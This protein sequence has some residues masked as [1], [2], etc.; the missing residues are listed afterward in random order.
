MR[1]DG[2]SSSVVEV[3]LEGL[4]LDKEEQAAARVL[5][6][7]GDGQM[8]PGD[9]KAAAGIW[10]RVLMV[11]AVGV[12]LVLGVIHGRELL[13]GLYLMGNGFVLN[14]T[15]EFLEQFRPAPIPGLSEREQ[16]L[17]SDWQNWNA[18]DLRRLTVLE[19]DDP[20]VFCAYSSTFL[21]QHDKLPEGY[22][23]TAQR[24]APNNACFHFQASASVGEGVIKRKGLSR[25][26]RLAGERQEYDIIDPAGMEAA[27]ELF[28][29]GVKLEGFGTYDS[30]LGSEVA[31]ILPAGTAVEVL[32]RYSSGASWS[33]GMPRIM[34]LPDLLAA[35]GRRLEAAGDVEGLRAHLANC[36]KFLQMLD[37]KPPDYL[38]F[39]VMYA[40]AAERLSEV[41]VGSAKALGLEKETETWER[42]SEGLRQRHDAV[43]D[44]SR[45]SPLPDVEKGGGMYVQT[46]P[47]W[48]NQAMQ[49][50]LF[51]EEDLV[52]SRRVE[53]A[54]V[55]RGAMVAGCGLVGLVML[56]P[57]LAKMGRRRW[58]RRLSGRMEGLLRAGDW[59]WIFGLGVALPL[60]AAWAWLIGAPWSAWAV[61]VRE[62]YAVFFPYLAMVL[63]CVNGTVLA[64][65]W[66]VRR[67]LAVFGMPQGSIIQMGWWCLL[68]I[69]LAVSVFLGIAPGLEQVVAFDEW[70]EDKLGE[71][72][73][74]VDLLMGLWFCLLLGLLAAG[75]YERGKN[76]LCRMVVGRVM[77]GALAFLML[78]MAL[79]LP[80]LKWHEK[81]CVKADT[82]V[83]AKGSESLWSPYEL[84]VAERMREE[85][86][87][88]LWAGDE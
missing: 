4:P 80:L 36:E 43:R 85:L 37:H 77:P 62:E 58:L 68:P 2:S 66:R 59:C 17:I 24:L 32:R 34:K 38:F 33:S 5:L 46:L 6:M 23:E 28:R 41:L 19:P 83:F 64:A 13:Q 53:H 54:V 30:Q 82:L 35:E 10:K 71:E 88:I 20:A 55:A 73:R 11:A 72:I 31:A 69:G 16:V 21:S 1:V 50:P 39:E 81:E 9:L 44:R 49:P 26:K 87:E 84:R 42:K 61:G 75:W 27:M 86:R 8:A 63:L 52:P 25:A 7:E 56:V 70:L 3:V 65:D 14:W 48:G 22:L 78:L 51:T 60:L 57:L 67:R 47:I 74:V 15:P 79:S 40:V 45:H 12:A 29:K 18:E 76:L